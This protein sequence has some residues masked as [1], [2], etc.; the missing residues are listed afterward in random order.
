MSVTQRGAVATAIFAAVTALR[1]AVVAWLADAKNQ[2]LSS[3]LTRWDAI[4]Y[5]SIARGG[6]FEDMDPTSLGGYQARL[7]FF[8]LFPY[9]LR[10]VR[11]ATGLDYLPA[12]LVI[13]SLAGVALV[14]AVMMI[15]KHMGAGT[16]G[17]VAGGV[18][19]AGA[20]MGLTYNM[21]YTE[22]LFSALA[23]WALYFM[24][25]QRWGL[26]GILVFFTCLTRI[27]GID[28]WIVFLLVVLVHGWRNCSAWIALALSPLGLVAYLIFVGKHTADLGGYFGIQQ[29]GWGSAFDYGAA[30]LEFL[31]WCFNRSSDSWLLIVGLIMLGTILLLA[32]SFGKLPWPIWLF[33]LGIALNILLSDGTITSRPR[34]LLP[35]V[36]CLLP[37]A[38]VLSK[39]LEQWKMALLGVTWVVLGSII[40]AHPLIATGWAI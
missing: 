13:N 36:I 1:L 5:I 12:A 23:F 29:K 33:A 6:Y 10:A 2:T 3:V 20:P 37:A 25:Q 9:L 21:P 19:I 18:L 26:V 24:L 14:A 8:P 17:Q 28:L 27:T 22:A 40:S 16:R 4:H 35:V 15:A 39:L 32:L 11:E 30:S 31:S 7:A 34:L 38:M